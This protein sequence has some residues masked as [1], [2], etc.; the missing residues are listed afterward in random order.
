[1]T[2]KEEIQ[3]AYYQETDNAEQY[4]R[5][6]KTV[7]DLIKKHCRVVVQEAIIILIGDIVWDRGNIA[8][9]AML[10]FLGFLVKAGC[11]LRICLSN[12]NIMLPGYVF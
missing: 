12:H 2:S 1:M 5:A 11:Y 9:G 4:F 6:Q 10:A 7:I 3:T 8:D